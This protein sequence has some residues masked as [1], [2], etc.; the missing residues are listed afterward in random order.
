M[1]TEICIF[2]RCI[3]LLYYHFTEAID[4]LPSDLLSV[5]E[6]GRAH[7]SY[8]VQLIIGVL[9][10]VAAEAVSEILGPVALSKIVRDLKENIV[11]VAF[12][13]RHKS[14]KSTLINALL[15]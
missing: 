11:S 4:D 1:H 10:Q 7:Y 8:T 15:W 9:L 6:V 5:C 3:T 13:G 14:G 12:V 2:E